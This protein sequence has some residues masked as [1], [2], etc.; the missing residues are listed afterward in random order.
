MCCVIAFILLIVAAALNLSWLV[1][2]VLF[3]VCPVSII[4]GICGISCVSCCPEAASVHLEP[5]CTR[6][7]GDLEMGAFYRN[8][9]QASRVVAAVSTDMHDAIPVSIKKA[10]ISPVSDIPTALVVA[11]EHPTVTTQPS[12]QP[13]EGESPELRTF[14]AADLASRVKDNVGNASR[15]V[16]EAIPVGY[17][18][19]QSDAKQIFASLSLSFDAVEVAKTLSERRSPLHVRVIAEAINATTPI[20]RNDVAKIFAK[21]LSRGDQQSL[22]NLV[23]NDDVKSTISTLFNQN[24]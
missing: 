17:V 24:F 5:D 18:L 8:T 13:V 10:S 16:E 4:V 21:N 14:D 19:T 12:T 15:F 9:H 1:G 2:L 22:C 3:L 6:G 7:Q 20:A 23:D 11:M